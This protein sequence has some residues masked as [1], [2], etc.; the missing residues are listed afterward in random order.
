M[1]SNKQKQNIIIINFIKLTRHLDL[2]QDI[3]QDKEISLKNI[4][5]S[6]I[7]I[8]K[9]LKTSLNKLLKNVTNLISLIKRIMNISVKIKLKKLLINLKNLQYI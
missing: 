6:I 5:F 4:T 1:K 3:I 9:I 8:F 7:K 2:T